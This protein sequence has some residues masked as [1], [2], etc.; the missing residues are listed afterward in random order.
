MAYVYRNRTA[1][2]AVL[3]AT[4]LLAGCAQGNAGNTAS[5][6]DSSSSDAAKTVTIAVHD[7]FPGDEFAA[8]ASKA[9]GYDVKVVETGD[10]SELANKLVLT[11]DAPIADAFFGVTNL[12]AA[13]LVEEGAVAP[14]KP[15]KQSANAANF[16]FDKADSITPIDEGSVCFNIDPA[17]FVEKGIPEPKTF[18]D[19]TAETYKGLTAII[20]PSASDTGRAL[21]AGTVAKF[22][23]EGYLDY[24][25]QLLDNGARLEQGWSA[26]YNGQF[27]Q[28]GENGTFPIVLSYA[29]SP[30][31]TVNDE[32]T[33]SSTKALLETCTDVVEYAGVLAGASNEAGAKAVIDYMVSGEFQA[34]IPDTMYMYPVDDSVELPEEWAKFAPRPTTRWNVPAER[35]GKEIETWVRD[36]LNN[37]SE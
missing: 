7:S 28:G 26:A 24:W 10:G 17:W 6:D 5:Q 30:A 14:Y 29:S 12:R 34:T 3:G 23:E 25:K 13:K 32:G 2:L 36:W 11:K 33:E 15:A 19:L 22:G 27:T 31:W 8:A 35:V 20:D 21:L 9:T 37:F 1:I 18:E 16:A 4:V